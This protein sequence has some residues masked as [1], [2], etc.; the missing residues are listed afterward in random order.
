MTKFVESCLRILSYLQNQSQRQKYLL[1]ITL[2]LPLPCVLRVF[3]SHLIAFGTAVFN[4][5]DSR[6]PMLCESKGVCVKPS[7]ET[8][9]VSTQS[10]VYA[11]NQS[12]GFLCHF[13]DVECWIYVALEIVI[14]VND[15][16]H[17]CYTK[18]Y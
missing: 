18:F 11:S 6:A 7:T 4:M 5:H 3:T 1:N 17:P 16:C 12:L 15:G 14:S 13:H 8:A 2:H 10:V 9:E